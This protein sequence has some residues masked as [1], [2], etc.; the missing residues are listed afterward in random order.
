MVEAEHHQNIEKISS[1]DRLGR[2][3]RK[4]INPLLSRGDLPLEHI[5]NCGDYIWCVFV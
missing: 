2:E 3:G 1:W 4:T 5:I